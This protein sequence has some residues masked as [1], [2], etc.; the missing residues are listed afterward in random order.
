MA[1]K[2]CTVL[3]GSE[4]MVLLLSKKSSG[5]NAGNSGDGIVTRDE[6]QKARAGLLARKDPL[7]TA[8]QQMPQVIEETWGLR[9]VF[10]FRVFGV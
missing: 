4:L 5:Q 1:G 8:G 7:Q 9:C 2:A 3:V 6:F 10:G